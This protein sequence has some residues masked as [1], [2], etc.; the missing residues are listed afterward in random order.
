MYDRWSL[1]SVPC[2]CRRSCRV[3]TRRFAHLDAPPGFIDGVNPGGW[4]SAVVLATPDGAPAYP[5]GQ[6]LRR[7]GNRRSPSA[8]PAEVDSAAAFDFALAADARIIRRSGAG[9][10]PERGARAR[11]T[12]W[13]F[14]LGRAPADGSVCSDGPAGQR[15]AVGPAATFARTRPR[16]SWAPTPDTF[17]PAL[18]PAPVRT[19]GLPT[20]SGI[21][22]PMH[23]STPRCRRRR[24]L[25]LR[26]LHTNPSVG[27]QR[28]AGPSQVADG[29][30]ESCHMPPRRRT[31]ALSQVPAYSQL[32]RKLC[33][34]GMVEWRSRAGA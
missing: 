21:P 14:V 2:S 30:S 24:P 19:P 20:T 7:R 5:P 16:S 33:F 17:A 4:R 13:T 18:R 10:P 11:A 27:A 25:P 22:Q 9:S 31:K 34:R 8:C 26:L 28:R 23:R 15:T 3:G 12:T 29:T 1:G 6:S 32:Q